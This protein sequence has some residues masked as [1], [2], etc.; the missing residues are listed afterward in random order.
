MNEFKLQKEYNWQLAHQPIL[1]KY[2]ALL[3]QTG[4]NA[5]VATVLENTLG[6]VVWSY[7]SIGSYFGTLVG[8]FPQ[9]K[10]ALF[11]Q[12]PGSL[13]TNVV[14]KRQVGIKWNYEDVIEVLS[15][16]GTGNI[17]T[18]GTNGILNYTAIEIRVYA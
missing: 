13:A 1:K 3:T 16:D 14:T 7:D 4:T 10:T 2:V 15:N 11:I 6:D 9:D 5:P 18:G 12:Q 8:A 17:L